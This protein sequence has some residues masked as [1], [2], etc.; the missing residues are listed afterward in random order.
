M[1]AAKLGIVLAMAVVVLT[2]QGVVLAG[3]VGVA[4]VNG[5]ASAVRFSEGLVIVVVNQ[6]ALIV[7]QCPYV[8][9]GILAI[10]ICHLFSV[11]E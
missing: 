5:N 2:G 8:A 3:G 9:Q 7:S 4:L 11:I 1:E 10:P 6:L